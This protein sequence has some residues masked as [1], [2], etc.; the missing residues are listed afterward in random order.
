MVINCL[1]LAK[2]NSFQM[3]NC[4]STGW[5]PL[6]AEDHWSITTEV[7]TKACCQPELLFLAF[8][9]QSDGWILATFYFIF[10]IEIYTIKKVATKNTPNSTFYFT[11]LYSSAPVQGKYKV[12]LLKESVQKGISCGTWT[13][14]VSFLLIIIWIIAEGNL[15]LRLTVCYTFQNDWRHHHGTS[16]TT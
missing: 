14:C 13:W 2:L 8:W 10:K 1:T 4:Y 11:I 12:N 7:S 16:I 6:F 9:I 15:T 3:A 5:F